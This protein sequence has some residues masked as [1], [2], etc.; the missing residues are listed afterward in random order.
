MD[1]LMEEKEQLQKKYEDEKVP[2]L[3]VKFV[4]RYINCVTPGNK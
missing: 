2:L 4:A 3:L 1:E